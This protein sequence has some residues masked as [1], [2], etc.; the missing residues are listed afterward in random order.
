MSER[1]K[2]MKTPKTERP[3]LI[4]TV[5]NE[6]FFGW[7]EDDLRAEH[8]TLKKA[9]MVVRYSGTHCGVLGLAVIGHDEECRISKA[10]E[11]L[12]V[13]DVKWACWVSKTALPRWEKEQWA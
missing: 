5:R 13:R 9:R 1:E 4:H 10:V 6:I 3:I 11:E 2:K 7:T 12:Y 8:M